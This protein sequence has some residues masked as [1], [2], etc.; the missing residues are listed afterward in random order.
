MTQF[1]FKEIAMFSLLRLVMGRNPSGVCCCAKSM[2]LS[3]LI[4]FDIFCNFAVIKHPSMDMR[5]A[6]SFY[7]FFVFLWEPSTYLFKHDA[8]LNHVLYV[9]HFLESS[10]QPHQPRVE[11]ALYVP[12]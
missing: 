9:M 3:P 11:E 4:F 12:P 1:G 2:H 5:S 10:P 8:L 7:M 6:G